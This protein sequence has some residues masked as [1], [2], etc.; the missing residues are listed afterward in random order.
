M[1]RTFALV[2]AFFVGGCGST[3]DTNDAGLDGGGSDGPTFSDTGTP[4]NG[5]SAD[6]RSI[7]DSS[8]NVVTT[9]PV[10]QGCSNG[11]C[12]DA[13]AAAAAS[14]GTL[15]CD[16]WIPTPI[17]YD[18]ES[19]QK[20]PCF[21]MFVANTW[22][23]PASLNVTRGTTT[24]DATLFGHVPDSTKPPAQWPAVTAQGVPIDDVAV[25]YLSSDPNSVFVEDTSV[26]LACPS[27]T[28]TTA[29]E[30]A[31]TGIGTAFHVTTNVPVTAYD[32][33]P[34]GGA[35]SHFPAAELVYPS[36]AWGLNYVVLATPVGTSASQRLKFAHIVA[37][38]NGTNVTFEPVVALAGGG[39]LS[40]VAASTS[41]TFTLDAGDYAQWETTPTENDL[42]GSIVLANKP[43]SVVAGSEFFRLQPV[44]E[45]GGEGTHAQIAPA[46]AL[47]FDYAVAPY[48]TRRADLQEESISYRIVGAVTGTS[49]AF[50]P[51]VGGAPSKVDQSQVADFTATGAFRV[52]SQDKDHPFAIAQMMSTGNVVPAFRTDCA[53][54]QYQSFPKTCGD[55]DFVPLLPTAQF[56]SKYVFFTDPTYSTTTLEIVR[57]K[58][59]GG[60]QD[61]TIDCLGTIGGW[62]PIG[63]SGELEF[64]RP[65]LVRAANGIG[66]CKNG[67]HVAQSAGSFGVIVY[68]LD[69]YSSYGYPA[70]GNAATLSGVIV[71]PK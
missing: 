25:L 41:T 17:T 21:A 2:F 39:T 38:S 34:F 31:G 58:G 15:G 27:P 63:T 52:K 12:I 59:A 64:A 66:T 19:G 62:Q 49:L 6:L 57:V 33:F 20:Q 71:Q 43:V 11:Q 1:K 48:A 35:Y 10:D 54:I 60:F 5:C 4:Q 28:A 40:A 46:G 61:V 9:C 23:K 13:C 55:E 70:G 51:P 56:L 18:V 68:G 53:T 50:D 69:T 65:D 7:V 32:I 16:F 47:G 24:Y 42:S 26:N 67:R 14:H 8:G 44:D 30:F 22:P 37:S 3:G 45:P 29:T 36:S